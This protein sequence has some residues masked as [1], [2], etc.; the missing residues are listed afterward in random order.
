MKNCKYILLILFQFI[1]LLVSSNNQQLKFERIGT[2]TGLTDNNVVCIMQDSRGFIWVGTQYGLNRFDGQ[3]FKVFYSNPFDS[4]SLGSNYIQNIFEDSN[5]NIWIATL[6]GGFCKFDRA[7]NRFKQFNHK[8]N[9]SNC[10][11]GNNI[12]SIVEDKTGKFWIATS[13]GIN[14]F[15]PETERFI[16]FYNEKNDTTTISNNIAT[17]V[18]ADSRGEIWI[19]TQ[20]GGLNK[21][22]SQD[23]TFIRYKTNNRNSETISGNYISAIFEDSGHRLWI[24]TAGEGLNLFEPE[25]GKFRRFKKSSE[26]NSLCHNNIL[27]IN[28]DD[29]N[30]LWIGTENGGISIFDY[31]LN[32]FRNYSNDEIDDSSLSAN[33]VVSITKDMDGNMWV[34]LFAGGINLYKK[35]TDSFNHFKHNSSPGSLSNNFVLSIYE[36][37][38]GNL[39]VGT[40]GGGLNRFDQKTG[41]SFLYK[42]NAKNNS[43]AGDFILALAEDEND[44]LWIGTWGNG[45]CR[46]NRKTQDFTEFKYIENNISGLNSDKITAITITRNRKIFI[47]TY[48]GGLNV[49]DPESKRFSH[50]TNKKN[51]TKSLSSNLVYSILEDKEGRIWIGTVDGGINLFEPENYSFIRF[52]KENKGLTNNRVPHLMENNS[53]VIFACT[54]GGGLNYFDPSQNRFARVECRNNSETDYV[55]AALEDRKGFIWISSNKGISKYDP[56][57]KTFKN[58]SVEDGLQGEEFKPHSAFRSNSGVLY[59]GGINGYNSF[60]PEQIIEKSYNP[61]IVLT[62]FLIFN[63]NVPI[64]QSEGDHSLLKM[65]ISEAKS[66]YLTYKESVITFGF[67]SLDFASP[68]TKI[69]AYMLDGFDNEWNVIGSKTSATY[70]NL[71]Q[72]NYIFKVKSKNRAG[73]WSSETHTLYLKVTPPFWLTWWFKILVLFLI[74]VS[75]WGFYKYRLNSINRQKKKLEALINKRTA[76]LVRQSV[77][78]K[79]VNAELQ[80]QS[81]ELQNQR[82]LEQQARQEA[83]YANRAKSTFLA[84]M[85][86]EIRTPMNGVIGMASLLSETKLTDEQRE[87]N[88]TILTCG[89]N[90]IT[91]IN[92]IL[93]FSKIESGNM[94]IEQE[95]FDLRSSIEEVMDLFSQKIALKGLDLMYHIDLDVPPQIV[96]DSLR[97]KQILINLINNAIKFTEK[98]EVYLAVYLISKEHDNSKIEIGFQVHDTGIGIPAERIAGLF[99]AFVQVDASTTRMYGGTGLGLAISERLVKLMGGAIRVES[100]FGQGST[101]VF[102]IK[103][104]ISTKNRILP[105]SGSICELMG[106][107]V[108]IV[109]DN[110]TNLKTLKI[111]LEQWKIVTYSV[112]SAHEA[113]SFLQNIG[114]RAIDLVITDMQMPEMDGVELATIIKTMNNSLPIIMLSSVGDETKKTFPDLFSFIL[115]KPVKQQRLFKSLNLLLTSH[116]ELIVLEEAKDGILLDSFA[117]EYP[118]NILVAEDN[119]INQK[120]IERILHKLGYKIDIAANGIQVLNSLKLKNYNVILMDIQMPEMDGLETTGIIRGMTIEQPYIIALTANAMSKDREECIKKGMNNYVS[121]PMRLHE[122]IKILKLA[123]SHQ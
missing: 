119:L 80:S 40:D 35:N 115:T 28:E 88:D 42:H 108:L 2:K 7:L 5:R 39:W 82:I 81:E 112:S 68:D 89:D 94:E 102:S 58:Y 27:S 33:C 121:K 26:I 113:I 72:G 100:V 50:F 45:L 51:D 69:Y 55:Q 59:F 3:Q 123:A 16:H 75:L 66:L 116:K 11:S 95:D 10:V 34:G 31:E 60:L 87:Y 117:D 8:L 97:L 61:P 83:E 77:K 12:N 111:Q 91:V 13:D 118:L 122:I 74:G 6:G 78:L 85:S 52:T 114:N 54:H 56:N 23:S 92:D 67:A 15:D 71:N 49:Y 29:K 36:D 4:C 20:G 24:G 18:Y 19:G 70:T 98:G 105:G 103:C 1:F 44:D 107:K 62:D 73:E 99:Q 9:D 106:K 30:N 79:E 101:F 22:V 104:S 53:G 65:D 32:K 120:L 41:S 25:K 47:G 84:T 63:K 90:L 109:D 37:H 14:L 21:F 76:S 64:A 96:G 110:L 48:G 93:D 46:F 38:I 43:I 57:S 17:T 86:H